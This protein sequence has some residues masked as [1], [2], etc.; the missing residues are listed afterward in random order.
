MELQALSWAL[1]LWQGVH[2]GRTTQLSWKTLR[3]VHPSS[4]ITT[5]FPPLHC[6]YEGMFSDTLKLVDSSPASKTYSCTQGF[7]PISSEEVLTLLD[8]PQGS[9]L[10]FGHEASASCLNCKPTQS[11]MKSMEFPSVTHFWSFSYSLLFFP[12]STSQVFKPP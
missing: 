7:N 8:L 3:T 11:Y 1:H 6:K 9:Q 5:S 4:S 10:T 2:G 12:L